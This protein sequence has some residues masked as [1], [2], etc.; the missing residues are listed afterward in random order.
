MN[1]STPNK[2]PAI[3]AP[4]TKERYQYEYTQVLKTLSPDRQARFRAAKEGDRW[5]DDL[6]KTIIAKAEYVP[7][8]EEKNKKT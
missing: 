4:A 7:D 2:A 6:V 1:T 3:P 8:P 5:V